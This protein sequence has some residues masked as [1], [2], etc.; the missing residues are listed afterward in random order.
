[1][2]SPA[3][4]T[5]VAPGKA[6]LMGEHFVVHGTPAL[7]VP[8][9]ELT[10]TAEL[11]RASE[12]VPLPEGHLGFCLRLLLDAFGASGLPVAVQIQSDIPVGSGLGSSAAL[13]VALARAVAD[14]LDMPLSADRE[15][16]LSMAC[17]RQAHG[18]PSGVDT[19]VCMTGRPVW[20]EQ[21]RFAPLDGPGLARVG[22]LALYCGPGGATSEMIERVAGFQQRAGDRFAQLATETRSRCHATREALLRGG[23]AD[24]GARLTQQHQVLQEIGVSTPALD[25]AV[26]AALAEGAA[27][28]KL[29]GAGGGG[30]AVAVSPVE[31]VADIAQRLRDRGQNVVTAGAIA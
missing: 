10:L 5:G 12:P 19:E 25:D 6:I 1:M 22:L 11:S 2:S 17:E 4:A 23:A 26:E 31:A 15:R 9:S 3:V 14:L 21:G 7:A 24:L 18:R 16:E 30:L 27:G 29:S 28:A 8:L 20:A 13:S